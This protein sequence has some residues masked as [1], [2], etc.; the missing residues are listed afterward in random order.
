MNLYNLKT[1]FLFYLKM[2]LAWVILILFFLFLRNYG[3]AELE[4]IQNHPLS[5]LDFSELLFLIGTVSLLAG[6]I[7]VSIEVLFNQTL[8]QKQSYAGIIAGKIVCYFF[9]VK[10]VMLLGISLIQYFD[11]NILE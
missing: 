8:F 6:A 4:T 7:Y 5:Q 9:G 3:R 1:T 2:T 10:I 11:S